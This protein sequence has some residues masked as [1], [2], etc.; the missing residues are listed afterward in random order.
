[1]EIKPTKE[2]LHK[3]MECYVPEKDLFFLGEE[4]LTT[5][6]DKSGVLVI[7]MD[8]F[9]KHSTYT[10]INYVNSYEYWNIKNAQYVV[11]A[12]RDWIERLAEEPREYILNSQLE[13]KRGL[14]L[15]IVF[16]D[17]IEKIPSN[18]VVDGHVIFQRGMWDLLD[19][20]TKEQLL[21][22]VVYK[23]WDKGE[24]EEI[25]DSLPSFLTPFA[26]AFSSTQGANCLAAVLFAI[27]KGQQEW[28]IHEWI[29]QKTFLETLKQYNYEAFLGD[30][31]NQNDVVIWQDENETIQHAAYYLGDGLYFNKH[32]QTIFNPWKILKEEQLYSEWKHLKPVTYRQASDL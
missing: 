4:F 31:L 32:G 10:H 2:V 16:V 19:V 18:Y 1:M 20:G 7:P 30:E 27:S 28:F 13:C 14:T 11:I 3:W 26:N 8:E 24:C 23:W 15:P 25:P 6:L 5:E 17:E 29:H 21:T 22:T 9:L 12:E